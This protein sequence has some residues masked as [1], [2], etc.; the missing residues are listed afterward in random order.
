MVLYQLGRLAERLEASGRREDASRL[1]E[2]AAEI[3]RLG[4]DE[5]GADPVE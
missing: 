4:V 2:I 5:V 3:R 1:R